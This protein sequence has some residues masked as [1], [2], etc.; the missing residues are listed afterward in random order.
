MTDAAPAGVR[1]A[2]GRCR[3]AGQ[4]VRVTGGN[5][6]LDDGGGAPIMI[7]DGGIDGVTGP[8]R[9]NGE[10]GP[11]LGLYGLKWGQKRSN[12]GFLLAITGIIASKNQFWTDSVPRQ[13]ITG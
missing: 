1:T 2:A 8:G 10:K 3:S 7:H 5:W 9:E 12:R 13:P 4:L 11:V 6:S